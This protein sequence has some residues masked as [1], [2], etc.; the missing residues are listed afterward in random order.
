MK[1]IKTILLLGLLATL[2]VFAQTNSGPMRFSN[3]SV[4]FNEPSCWES[5][6]G[7]GP[8]VCLVRTSAN[9]LSVTQGDGVTGATLAL[10]SPVFT[11][12]N[13]GA[14]GTTVNL[15]AKITGAPS[16]A[17]KAGTGDNK[18]GAVIGVVSG[19]AGITGNAQITTVGTV[20][21]AFDATA[22]TAGDFVTV[23]ST[24]RSEERRV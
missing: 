12:A 21:C 1:F 16:T 18:N 6:A 11:I 2:P 13:E 10:G 5:T 3:T 14:T 9:T 24:V 22:V 19:G 20:G 15:L 17:I 8:D 23:S 7:A 4:I